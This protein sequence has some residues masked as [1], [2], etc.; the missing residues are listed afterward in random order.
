MWIDVIFRKNVL[1][2]LHISIHGAQKVAINITI[3]SLERASFTLSFDRSTSL[4]CSYMEIYLLSE[5]VTYTEKSWLTVICKKKV[6]FDFNFLH[7]HFQLWAGLM[8]DVQD[9]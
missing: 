7:I 8:C 9:R 5:G 4:Y 6:S 1:R 2:I 3:S